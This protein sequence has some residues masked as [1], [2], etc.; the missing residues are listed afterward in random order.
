MLPA[1][2]EV[3]NQVVRL[4]RQIGAL[5]AHMSAKARHGVEWSSYVL[6]LHLVKHGEPMRA[7][8][9]AD[10]VCADP[11]TVSRQTA[12]LVEHGLVERRADPEDGRAVQLAATAKGHELFAQM[13]DERVQTIAEVLADWTPQ[14]AHTLAALMDRFNTDLERHRP[15]LMQRLDTQEIA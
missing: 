11:S 8:S 7:S 12:A 3:G 10:V 2:A 6:L 13:R 9:L 4:T 5:R 14:D 15:R 1:A